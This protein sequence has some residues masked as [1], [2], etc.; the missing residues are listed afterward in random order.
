ML[1]GRLGCGTR[2]VDPGMR[3][4]KGTQPPHSRHMWP[5]CRHFCAVTSTATDPGRGSPPCSASLVPL[6][7]LTLL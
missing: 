7:L 3:V 5:W 4:P 2:E 6:E 1:R